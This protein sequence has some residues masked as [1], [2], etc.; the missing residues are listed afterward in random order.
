MTISLIYYKFIVRFTIGLEILLILSCCSKIRSTKS[1]FTH[2]NVSPYTTRSSARS[3]SWVPLFFY[4][5]LKRRFI[6]INKTIYRIVEKKDI[7]T[8]F[9]V[10]RNEREESMAAMMIIK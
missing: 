3:A 2:P 1:V 10:K 8:T 7:K 4:F 5:F 6:E 9:R